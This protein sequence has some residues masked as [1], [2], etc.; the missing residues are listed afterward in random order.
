MRFTVRS[1]GGKLVISAALTLLLCM[2]FFSAGSW[3]SL[4]FYYEHTA[5]NVATRHLS[6]LEEAYK[7]Q[8]NVLESTHDIDDSF[9]SELA[10]AASNQL[11][12]D[13]LNVAVCESKHIR[14]TTM[15]SFTAHI[16]ENDLCTPK[17]TNIINDYLTFP[18][19]IYQIR[20]HFITSPSLAF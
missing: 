2:L 14:G 17:E 12:I 20:S 15:H 11:R 10:Q 5:I 1:L 7:A 6:S 4:N 8:V 3:L 13:E 16:S 9:A 18:P 19:H